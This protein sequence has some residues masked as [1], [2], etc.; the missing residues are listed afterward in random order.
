[1]SKSTNS[2]RVAGA[3]SNSSPV[4]HR[5][6]LNLGAFCAS[7]WP[8]A[9]ISRTCLNQPSQ[10]GAGWLSG[11]SGS[12]KHLGFRIISKKSESV[13]KTDS[14]GVTLY[15]TAMSRDDLGSNV[16]VRPR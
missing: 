5:D 16:W 1:M 15:P 12:P 7:R 11:A 6:A 3:A 4:S 14:F 10:P 2:F 13:E 9:L 8:Q